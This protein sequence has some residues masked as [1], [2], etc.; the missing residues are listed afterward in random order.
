MLRTPSLGSMANR[1]MNSGGRK[2]VTLEL[3]ESGRS[4][5]VA[6]RTMMTAPG[7]LFSGMVTSYKSLEKR[8]GWSL[9][10]EILT[11]RLE[12]E[13][14]GGDPSSRQLILTLKL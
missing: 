14:R 4:W 2:Y 5:S 13:E 8:G 7:E 3:S 12:L 6:V 9:R 11:R 10:S 1:V